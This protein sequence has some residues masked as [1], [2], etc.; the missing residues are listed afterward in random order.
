MLKL[1]AV[2]SLHH[3]QNESRKTWRTHASKE[4]ELLEASNGLS[5]EAGEVCGKIQ[6]IAREDSG[7]FASLLESGFKS[8]REAIMLE[9]GDVLYYCA[10]V[11]DFFGFTLEEA[12][13]ANLRKLEKRFNENKIKGDGD[14]R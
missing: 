6:K 9:I 13:N 4:L 11:A 7:S 2:I 1:Q 8:L 14:Y 3:Y 12:A 5:S 10:R